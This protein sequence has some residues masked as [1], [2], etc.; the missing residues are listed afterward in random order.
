MIVFCKD[1]DPAVEGVSRML[2]VIEG[3]INKD[4]VK[5]VSG[6]FYKDIYIFIAES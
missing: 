1:T 2:Q 5:T 6:C 4:V 3:I